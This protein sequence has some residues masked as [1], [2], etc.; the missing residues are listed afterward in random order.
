MEEFL[1]GGD[2]MPKDYYLILGIT[3]DASLDDI[4]DAYRRLAKRYHPDRYGEN[5]TP[6]IAIQ[7]AYSVLSDP[8]KRQTHDIEVLHQKKAGP[9]HGNR[10]KSGPRRDVEPLIPDQ[11]APINLGSEN[12]AWPFHAYRPSFHDVFD[13]LFGNFRQRSQ[14]KRVQQTDRKVIIRLTSEQAFQGGQLKLTLPADLTCPSCSGQG[15]AGIHECRRC[16]GEGILSGEYPIMISYPPG[17]ADHH[18]VRIPLNTYEM[19]QRFL[20]VHFRI[21]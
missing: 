17:I 13:R 15:G 8:I 11:K 5:H 20:I 16:N 12:F 19:K 21:G 10:I 2:V 3:S 4:K 9:P 14:P 1:S 18:T 7:E 6:F